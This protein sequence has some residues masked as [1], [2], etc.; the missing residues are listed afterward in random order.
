[1]SFKGRELRPDGAGEAK[2]VDI[3]LIDLPHISNFTDLDALALE[4]DVT[5]RPVLDPA[6]LGR[7]DAVILPAARTRWATSPSCANAGSTRPFWSWPTA[8]PA[9]W[10][11]C[12]R[13]SR[14][15]AG[16]HGPARLESASRA[17]PGLGLLP[18]GTVLESSKVLTRREAVHAPSGLAVKGYEIHHGRTS[19]ETG[20]LAPVVTAADG[21]VLGWGLPGRRVWGTYLHGVSTPTPSAGPSW[22][23]CAGQGLPPGGR[24]GRGLRPGA[25]ARPPGRGPAPPPGPRAHPAPARPALSAPARNRHP[26]SL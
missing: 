14:C 17:S 11:A 1:M 9:R 19:G 26:I 18:L 21:A 12:A 20:G 5:V 10:S 2:V 25:G 23:A 4:P 24:G 13:A 22:T 15:S 3:A 7:P 16:N 8:A 6:D